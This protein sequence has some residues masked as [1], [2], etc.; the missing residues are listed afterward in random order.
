MAF[1][2]LR[3]VLPTSHLVK[4]H[5]QTTPC[6]DKLRYLTEALLSV[7]IENSD[8]DGPPQSLYSSLSADVAKKLFVNLC[9]NGNRKIQLLTG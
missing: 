1:Y 9:V 6:R 3:S 7:L 5:E 8:K 4:D 2:S